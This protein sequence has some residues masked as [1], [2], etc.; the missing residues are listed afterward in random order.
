MHAQE[1][2]VSRLVP[3]AILSLIIGT[4][5]YQ[6]P[7]DQLVSLQLQLAQRANFRFFLLLA[8]GHRRRALSPFLCVVRFQLA[9][10]F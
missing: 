8:F 4:L 7:R 2:L 6:Q 9:L 10:R 3:A 1:A 5:Y